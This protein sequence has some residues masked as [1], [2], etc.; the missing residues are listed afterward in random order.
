MSLLKY[1]RQKVEIPD[2]TSLP[3]VTNRASGRRYARTSCDTC[4]QARRRHTREPRWRQNFRNKIKASSVKSE[5]G[6]GA[7]GW[8]VLGDP[9]QL[10]YLDASPNFCNKNK[11]G[12]GTSGRSCERGESCGDLCCGRG[13]DTS[14]VEVTEPCKCRVVWCCDV[15]CLNCTRV[16]ELYTCK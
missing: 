11:Y 6:R 8:A 13:Y 2:E 14:V 16:T 7:K 12:P 9:S 4:L 3:Q 5:P 15:Q 1:M 10:V